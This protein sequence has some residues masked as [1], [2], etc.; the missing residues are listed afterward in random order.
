MELNT[1]IADKKAIN[2]RLLPLL[3]CQCGSLKK[4]LD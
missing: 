1:K 3:I 4:E 2:K